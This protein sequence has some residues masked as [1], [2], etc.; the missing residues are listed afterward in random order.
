MVDQ[1]GRA[2]I[3]LRGNQVNAALTEAIFFGLMR[4]LDS[5][6]PSPTAAEVA[7]IIDSYKENEAIHEAL[8][9]STADEEQVNKRLAAA[10]AAFI[11]D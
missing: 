5:D 8:T 2:A 7:E 3:R 4:R 6:A 11:G 10:V 9:R 1:S